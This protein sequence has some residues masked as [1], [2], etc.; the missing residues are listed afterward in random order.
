[1]SCDVEL[2]FEILAGDYGNPPEHFIW[3]FGTFDIT[4]SDEAE[5]INFNQKSGTSDLI[6][7]AQDI[8]KVELLTEEDF[9][10]D[11]TG[12]ALWALGGAVLSGPL[13]FAGGLL[14]VN[15]KEV[16]FLIETRV[17]NKLI[18]KADEKSYRKILDQSNYYPEA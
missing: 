4:P 1:M 13:G 15:K 9:D 10:K 14:S 8:T 7:V 5:L 2:M 3:I 11:K 6:S 12:T 17:G 16:V 18:A